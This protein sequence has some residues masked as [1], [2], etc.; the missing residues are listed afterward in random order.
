[1]KYAFLFFAALS[2]L[3]YILLAFVKNDHDV[4]LLDTTLVGLGFYI[5]LD[6]LDEKSDLP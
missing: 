5:V 4:T 6:K 2:M 3:G 1:M